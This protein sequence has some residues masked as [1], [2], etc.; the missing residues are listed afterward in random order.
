MFEDYYMSERNNNYH[1]H[2]YFYWVEP[3]ENETQT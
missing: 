2:G 3:E 1:K